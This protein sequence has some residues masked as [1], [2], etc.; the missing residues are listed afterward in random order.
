MKFS[1]TALMATELGPATSRQQQLFIKTAKFQFKARLH[2]QTPRPIGS[3]L[4]ARAAST[5]RTLTLT[6]YLMSL[7]VKSG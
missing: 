3:H 6:M 7:K 2:D 5:R 1:V 4:P